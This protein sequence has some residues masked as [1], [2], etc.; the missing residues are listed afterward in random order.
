MSKKNMTVDENG[1]QIKTVVKKRGGVGAF[2]CGFFFCLFFII[3]SVVGLGLYCYYNV[4]LSSVER[5]LGVTIPLEGEY[6]DLALK[7]LIAEGVAYR[8]ISLSGLE[9]IGVEL[10]EKIPGTEI[11]LTPLYTST[12][13]FNGENVAVNQ[14]R[15][16]DIANGLDE[17]VSA[18]LPV[19]YGYTTVQQVLDT[20]QVTLPTDLGYPALTEPYYNIGTA[21][22]PRLATLGELTISQALDIL[23]QHYSTENL[24]VQEA[25]NALGLSILDVEEGEEDVYADLRNLAITSITT[26]ILLDS[27]DGAFLN[28]LIDLSDF[29]FATSPEFNS[30]KLSGMLDYIRA[31]PLGEIINIPETTPDST[32]TDRL[33]SALRTVTFTDLS[34]GDIVENITAK[35]DANDPDLTLGEFLGM[36]ES[37]NL[38][39]LNDISFTSLLRDP[40]T[41]L[42]D[43]LNTVYIG[44]FLTLESVV[45]EDFAT[46]NPEFSAI[47]LDTTLSNLKSTI[48]SLTI[49]QIFTPTELSS[50]DLS[51]EEQNMTMLELLTNRAGSTLGSILNIDASRSGYL[52]VLSNTTSETFTA[53]LDSAS[54][55]DLLGAENGLSTVARLAGLSMQEISESEDLVG[56]LSENFGTL[57]DFLGVSAS[58]GGILSIIAN[59]TFDDLLG[60]NAGDAVMN[61][62]RSSDMTLGEMLGG[63]ITNPLIESVMSIEVGALFGDSPEDAFITALSGNTLGELFNITDNTGLMSFIKNV[64]MADLLGQTPGVT[65]ADAIM[66]AICGTNNEV[67]LAQ[68]LGSTESDGIMSIIQNVKM[69]DLL[70]PS[71]DATAGDAIMKAL[72]GSNMT[73]GS[74]LGITASDGISSVLATLTVSELFSGGDS[75]TS[76]IED[77]VGDIAD[78]LTLDDVFTGIGSGT[79]I[80]DKLYKKNPD[81]K[82]SDLANEIQNLTVAEAVGAQTGIFCLIDENSYQTTTLG[83]LSTLKARTEVSIQDL[84]S[85]GVVTYDQLSELESLGVDPSTTTFA[86]IINAYIDALRAAQGAGGS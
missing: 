29:P 72:A 6:K 85:A 83:N 41:T 52:L 71:G 7:E 66:N 62:L 2:F 9:E 67:T 70:R 78:T 61:A 53:T 11:Q 1:V 54:I 4:T 64:S 40:S 55:Y 18:I 5:L 21:E 86:T 34:E 30:T 51:V 59:V 60:A 77:M 43:T 27:V 44:D 33:L 24:T 63:E 84:Y 39:F 22:Q 25:V 12:I 74:L 47:P 20:A 14:I 50:L 57:G 45:P 68:F 13:D 73:L 17:F 65:P 58:D 32:A 28:N 76:A 80:L 48:A 49:N 35:I 36:A 46:I 31:V 3:V 75:A 79:S 42:T 26:D 82:I 19:M 8:D 16:I 81:A 38:A 37:S 23:P 15:I 10:P 56:L 69:A